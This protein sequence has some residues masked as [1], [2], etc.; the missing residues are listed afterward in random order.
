M[1]KKSGKYIAVLISGTILLGLSVSSAYISPA[2][3]QEDEV[4]DEVDDEIKSLSEG[5]WPSFGRDERNTR[6]S[7]YDT[8][9]IDSSL[10][11]T[12]DA[13]SAVRSSPAIG[14]EGVM[15]FGSIDSNLYAVDVE[16]G[17]E[18]WTFNTDEMI[19]S[20]PAVSE[21]EIIYFGSG[22]EHIYAL[23]PDG[24]L[25]WRYETDGAVF[26]SPTLDEDGNVYVGSYDGNLYSIDKDGNL[27]WE[28]SSDSWLW[29]SPS[30]S[31]EGVVYVG[32]GDNNLYAIDKT[33]GTELWNYA[34]GDDIY[35]SPSIGED[36]IYFGSYDGYLYALDKEG[37]LK[38]NYDSGAQIRTSPAVDQDGTIY[39]GARN[40]NVYGVKEGTEEWTFE[41]GDRVRS[42]PAVSADGYLY[43]G[44]DDGNL[45]ALNTDG[46]KVWTYEAGDDVY[47]SPAIG[48]DGKIYVG[49][50][51][52]K[53]YSFGGPGEAVE[54]RFDD[55]VTQT[56]GESFDITI[57]AYDDD[58]NV[59]T[60]YEGTVDLTDTTGTIDPVE[61]TF[62]EGEWSGTVTITEA[63]EDI[64]ITAT[65]QDDETVE[66]TNNEFDVEPAEVDYVDIDPVTDQTIT[67]GET[68]DFSAEAYDQYDNL[69][70]DEDTNFMWEN[71]T[72][73]G[74]FEETAT[75]EYDV[76][77]TY[78]EVTSPIVTVTVE[79]PD[80]DL[81]I[82]KWREVEMS[83]RIAGRKGNSIT[84]VLQE[85]G[86]VIESIELVREPGKPQVETVE[87]K[88]RMTGNYTLDLYYESEG[89]GANP[90]W[91]NFTCGDNYSTLFNN[92]KHNSE[93]H[94]LSYD[95]NEEIGDMVSESRTVHFSAVGNFDEDDIL[96]YEWDFGD[97]NTC[98][99]RNTSHEYSSPGVYDITLTVTLEYGSVTILEETV[100]IG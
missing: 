44:S 43:V 75:G 67:A 79:T 23:N 78:Q 29:S 65:D 100:E 41:T 83:V 4:D 9:H 8:G 49:S 52:G 42:S 61:A 6:L 90:V 98:E 81:E 7:P 20:S 36:G 46:E 91:V 56:A 66:G 35:S 10:D 69:I 59:A 19:I 14:S 64:T 60:G 82:D 54:F 39:F 47:S 1:N 50:V 3:V 32:S 99:S 84:A 87:M 28:F 63:D 25:R 89:R 76:K 72:E 16:D 74:L 93:E 55:I 27:N 80:I 21:E 2:G 34:T 15:Y 71:T 48:E 40:G 33:D 53:M 31:E 85:D 94:E 58:G 57:T 26:S 5:P 11:W 13:G 70:E 37:N 95:I 88:Y 96:S 77:A 18:Q 30:I 73:D 17:E 62:T 45:Y 51:N 68:I 24:S 22:D 97:G 92:F 86:E 38:W 12:H